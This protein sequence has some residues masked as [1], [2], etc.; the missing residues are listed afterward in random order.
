SRPRWGPANRSPDLAERSRSRRRGPRRTRTHESP[1]G[2]GSRGNC[3]RPACGWRTATPGRRADPAR[4]PQVREAF[5]GRLADI[6]HTGIVFISDGTAE[7]RTRDRV[8]RAIGERGPIS[9][10]DLAGLLGLTPAAVRR[11]LDALEEAE[12]I[13]EHEPAPGPRGRGRPARSFVLTEQGQEQM[14]NVYDDVAMAALKFLA[15]RSGEGA[16]EEFA[17]EHIHAL[18]QRI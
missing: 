4:S 8:R 11:H 7:S 2:R 3:R 9:A 18:E 17:E 13:A 1:A 14:S 12:L 16:V 15:E 5:V 6:G 10:R